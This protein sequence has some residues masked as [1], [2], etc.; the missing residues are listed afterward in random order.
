MSGKRRWRERLPAWLRQPLRFM[1]C[2]A[3]RFYNDHCLTDASALA[4]TTLLSMVPLLALVFAVLKGLGAQNLINPSSLTNFGLDR[5]VARQLLEYI[6]NANVGTLGSM[7]AAALALTVI[8]LLGSIEASFNRIWRVRR[9]RTVLRKVS[10]YLSVVFLTPLLLLAAA[11]I[12]SSLQFHYVLDWLLSTQFVGDAVLLALRFVPIAIN[13]LALGILYSVMPNRRAY[14]VAVVVA[15]LI[16]GLA[17]Q[18]VQVTYLA[19]QVGLA[20]YNALYGALAQLPFT[21]VWLYVSWVVILAGAQVAAVIEFG[22]DALGARSA[23]SQANIALHFLLRAADSF[24]TG[25]DPVD[26]LTVSGTLE[27]A[28][29]RVGDVAD[30]LCERGWLAPV[31]GRA[32]RFILARDPETIRLGALAALDDGTFGVVV[33]KRVKTYLADMG[34]AEYR[35]WES[36]TLAELLRSGGETPQSASRSG[37]APAAAS[38]ASLHK[39][40]GVG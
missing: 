22:V 6:D 34:E 24:A 35:T 29:E 16:A 33:D 18:L 25:G 9:S 36:Q 5:E 20:R 17:W 1:R 27:V 40:D 12:T 7:G 39:T 21:L 38:D 37:A 8:G 26:V 15:S 19:Q 3:Q 10:D 4:Y 14:P 11:A 32:G 30:W 13:S 2:V 23:P 31:G 28:P